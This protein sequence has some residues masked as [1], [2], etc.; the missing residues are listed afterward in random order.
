MEQD[1]GVVQNHSVAHGL[2]GTLTIVAFA[3]LVCWVYTG[4]SEG[5]ATYQLQNA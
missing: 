4:S 2:K 5:S 1:V 3:I